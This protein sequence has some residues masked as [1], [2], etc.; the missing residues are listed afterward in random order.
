MTSRNGPSPLSK[1]AR[2][3][4]NKKNP[5]P[6]TGGRGKGEGG[7]PEPCITPSPQPSPPLGERELSLGR[8]RELRLA[9]PIDLGLTVASHGWVRLE[10]WR[11]QSETGTL[12][13]TERI[14][15]RIGTIGV[16]QRDP[17]TLAVA[18]DEFPDDAAREIL[19]R[20]GRWVSAE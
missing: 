9:W 13:H 19:R 17:R 1:R 12:L 14:G 7:G 20:V 6:P 11:W 10:P 5:L 2:S 8:E 3:P 4:R 15:G 16:R 18:W